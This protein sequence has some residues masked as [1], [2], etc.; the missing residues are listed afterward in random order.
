MSIFTDI[1]GNQQES[2]SNIEALLRGGH[3][4]TVQCN[5]CDRK[6]TVI[7]GYYYT[8]IVCSGVLTPVINNTS[9]FF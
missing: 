9:L 1:A 6:V 5:S 7:S 4:I 2:I 8:C 3:Y